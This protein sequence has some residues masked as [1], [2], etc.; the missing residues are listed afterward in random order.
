LK[1]V[2]TGFMGSGKSTLAKAVASLVSVDG[3]YIDLDQMVQNKTGKRITELFSICG[4]SGFR[5]LESQ[6]LESVLNKSSVHYSWNNYITD[7]IALGGGTI[8]NIYN[9]RLLKRKSDVVIVYLDVSFDKIWSRIKDDL[10]RPLVKQGYE[11]LKRLYFQRQKFYN[12]ADIVIDANEKSLDCLVSELVFKLRD[13]IFYKRDI[14]EFR[15]IA[16][17]DFNYYF[18]SYL[19]NKL[20]KGFHPVISIDKTL[21]DKI[22]RRPLISEYNFI[23]NELFRKFPFRDIKPTQHGKEPRH[24]K[25]E[26]VKVEGYRQ[27][28][29][30]LKA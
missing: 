20:S 4:E 15:N 8:A 6:V 1:L 3:C 5:K 12:V 30:P 25:E 14:L 29:T 22:I 2:L 10:E 17:K 19:Y 9:L 11:N 28:I 21:M 26:E 16:V 18:I 23:K 7:I 13:K 27:G 24:Y